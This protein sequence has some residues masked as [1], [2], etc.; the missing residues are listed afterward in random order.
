M[1][2]LIVLCDPLG[3]VNEDGTRGPLWSSDCRPASTLKGLCIELLVAGWPLSEM[4]QL[5]GAEEP[6]RFSDIYKREV[7]H[8]PKR[9]APFQRAAKVGH[10]LANAAD[11]YGLGL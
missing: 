7:G 4:I 11:P 10:Q 2:P 3:A 9:F 6:E 1:T 8:L 5:P